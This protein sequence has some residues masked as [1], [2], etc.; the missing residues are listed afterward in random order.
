LN[1][2]G[3]TTKSDALPAQVPGEPLSSI[4]IVSASALF[5]LAS[6]TFNRA[7]EK[8]FRKWGFNLTEFMCLE[9]LLFRKK[10]LRP[11]EI[12]HLL[13]IEQN[14]V[15]MLLDR[16]QERKLIRRKRS[17]Y[18][19]RAVEVSLSQEGKKLLDEILPEVITLV[20][21]IFKNSISREEMM[22]FTDITRRIR[23]ASAV[24]Q[25]SRVDVVE[26]I[27]KQFTLPYRQV[28]ERFN[29]I[30]INIR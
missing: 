21:E 12:A 7:L 17:A 9:V 25:G 13:P 14:A 26:S 2:K 3:E 23:N 22:T 8:C 4:E 15:S 10:S 28:V 27:E 5:V 24:A 6:I 19:K 18:D 11:S 29:N 20:S 1:H 16:L 30:E